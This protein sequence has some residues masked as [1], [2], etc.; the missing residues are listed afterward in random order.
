VSEQVDAFFSLPCGQMSHRRAS[1]SSA[2]GCRIAGPVLPCSRLSHRRASTSPAVKCRI[3]SINTSHAVGCRIGR[4]SS[5]PAVS[6]RIAGP[7]LPLQSDVA[8][9][10]QY[11][12]CSQLS[13]RQHSS[14]AMELTWLSKGSIPGRDKNSSIR[15]DI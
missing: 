7:V 6:C 8:S 3:G 5:Y 2:V 12:P 11:F 4:T 14:P 10:G 13:Q 15:H 1:T 9:Q